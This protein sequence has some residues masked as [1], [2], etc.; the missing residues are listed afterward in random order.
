MSTK[1]ATPG[2]PTCG[3]T[4]PGTSGTPGRAEI[5]DETGF[6][7]QGTRSAGVQRQYSGTADRTENCQVGV[8][9]AYASRTWRRVSL[10]A[11]QHGTRRRGPAAF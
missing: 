4:S 2:D 5:A 3:T 8:V 6:I 7:K 11:W 9:L 1:P 10:S